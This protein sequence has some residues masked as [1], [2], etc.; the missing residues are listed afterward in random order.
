MPASNRLVP[1]QS[2][3]IDCG[4]TLAFRVSPAVLQR[5]QHAMNADG[6]CETIFNN[7]GFKLVRVP[8]VLKLAFSLKL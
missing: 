2:L 5:Y 8:L 7:D 1:I 4:L 3:N 6:L